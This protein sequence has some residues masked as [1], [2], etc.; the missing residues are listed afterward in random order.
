MN[1]EKI[2]TFAAW[3]K[4]IELLFLDNNYDIDIKTDIQKYELIY[5]ELEILRITGFSFYE[6]Y[7]QKYLKN[8]GQKAINEFKN[9]LLKNRRL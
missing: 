9:N 3:K 7:Y 8:F 4:E 5:Q 1:K 6:W 2:I